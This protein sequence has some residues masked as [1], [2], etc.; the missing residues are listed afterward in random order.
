MGARSLCR[1]AKSRWQ[2]ENHGFNE[3]RSRHGLEHI[4][5][6]EPNSLLL[7]WLIVVLVLTRGR[8]YGCTICLEERI[9]CGPRSNGFG[10]S[11]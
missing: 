9:P 7:Q 6:H 3:A 1:K 8:L 10:C 5:H 2:I 4:C 11:G